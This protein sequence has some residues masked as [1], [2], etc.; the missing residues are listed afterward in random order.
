MLYSQDYICSKLLALGFSKSNSI[1]T[2][3]I[4]Y[5]FI[6]N[7]NYD[8]ISLQL[9]VNKYENFI[10]TNDIKTALILLSPFF[11]SPY[12][13][14]LCDSDTKGL[15]IYFKKHINL[16]SEFHRKLKKRYYSSQNLDKCVKIKSYKTEAEKI[17]QERKLYEDKSKS[18]IKTTTKHETASFKQYTEK[19]KVYNN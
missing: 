18:V 19:Y 7:Y 3:F 17:E 1:N 12:Q 6:V 10:D 5:D 9:I 15:A 11:Q 13:I 8:K 2:D 14:F 16:Q 4:Q